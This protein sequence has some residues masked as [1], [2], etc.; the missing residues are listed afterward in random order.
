MK[1][2]FKILT[3]VMAVAALGVTTAGCSAKDK[4][5][6]WFEQLFCEHKY[7][8]GVETQAPTCTEEGVLTYTCTECGKTKKKDIAMIEHTEVEMPSVSPTCTEVGYAGGIWCEVCELVIE[9][10]TELAALGHLEIPD[11]AVAA[12][13]TTSGLTD[14]KHCKR[15]NEVLKAQEKVPATGHKIVTVAGKAATCTEEGLT[16][17]R[18]CESCGKVF[19]AQE[20]IPATGHMDSNGDFSCDVCGIES[21]NEVNP[22]VGECVVGKTYRIYSAKKYD[23]GDV[24][25]PQPELQIS[26]TLTDGTTK[27]LSVTVCGES[28]KSV[29]ISGFVF[30]DSFGEGYR[31]V[32]FK[33]GSYTALDADG[34]EIAF[35]IDETSV[36]EAVISDNEG[37]DSVGFVRRLESTSIANEE[38]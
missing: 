27:I 10:Q 5:D 30:E 8:E 11:K 13:C 35:T 2:K 6:K 32:T 36:I 37:L 23:G 38:D 12:T 7:D 18:V 15:C 29:N 17:G 20:T 28:F 21:L 31:D 33:V 9:E 26:V 22:T 34:N 1:R 19:V 3:A 24:Y 4:T 16:D 14:G 25:G